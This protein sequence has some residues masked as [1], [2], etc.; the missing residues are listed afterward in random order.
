[1]THYES[2]KSIFKMPQDLIKGQSLL[3]LSNRQDFAG[4]NPAN[5]YIGQGPAIVTSRLAQYL[6][7]SLPQARRPTFMTATG[8][9]CRDAAGDAKVGGVLVSNGGNY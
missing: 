9:G 8:A 3:S 5:L 4:I 6:A 2:G 1:M 7:R